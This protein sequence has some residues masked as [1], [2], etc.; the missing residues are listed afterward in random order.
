MTDHMTL[1]MYHE[2]RRITDPKIIMSILDRCHVATLVCHDE[3][4]PY[5]V[6]MNFGYCWEEKPVFYLHMVRA[7]HRLELLQRDP[8]VVLNTYEW[9]DRRGYQPYR[10]EDHDYRS[11]NVFGTARI[12]TTDDEE[13][14]LKGLSVLQRHNSRR[15]PTRITEDMKK[16][17]LVLR[18]TGEIITARSQFPLSS[19]EESAIRPNIPREKKG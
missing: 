7:G 14:Y 4:Y 17:L 11:I 6:P 19:P 8:R 15:P 2:D 1:Q 12:I 3:P 9:L 13:E 16:R 5:V 18:V 10:G